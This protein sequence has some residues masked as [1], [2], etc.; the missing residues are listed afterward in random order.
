MRRV[1]HPHGGDLAVWCNREVDDCLFLALEWL[2]LASH[3]WDPP[4]FEVGDQSPY[5][6]VNAYS[7]CV[8]E[9]FD[10]HLQT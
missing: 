10:A 7:V 4:F 5:I 2:C 1:F 9:Q 8:S 6:R 3:E